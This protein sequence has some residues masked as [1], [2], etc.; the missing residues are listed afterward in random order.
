MLV[1]GRN[2][3]RNGTLLGKWIAII[4]IGCALSTV[5]ISDRYMWQSVVT[6]KYFWF[7]MVMCAVSLLIPFQLSK[8]KE[9][10]IADIL[11]GVLL[12]YICIN[13]F[14]LNGRPNMRLWLTLLMIPL[15]V[16][17]RTV[18]RNE[19]LMMWLIIV[20]MIVVFVEALVGLLQL[21]GFVRSHHILYK[22]TGTLFNPGPFSGFVAVGVP[23]ALRYALDKALPRWVRWLGISTLGASILVLSATMSRAAWM[24]TVAGCILI[25]ANS[26]Q[27]SRFK[28]QNFAY[29][30][31]SSTVI[32]IVMVIAAVLFVVVLTVGAYLLKKD[33]ADGRW[34]IWSA[35]IEAVKE[36]PLFGS[37]YGRFAAVYGNAQAAYFQVG[38]GSEGQK[39]VADSP[40][41]AFNEYVQM[42]VELGIAGL[43]LFLCT[44]GSVFMV[45]RFSVIHASLLSFI[46]FAA[47]SYPFSVLPLSILFVFLLAFSAPTS[48][49]LSISFPVWLRVAVTVVCW[50]IAA[51][52]SFQIL[53]KRMAY[54]DW[55]LAQFPYIEQSYYL[56]VKEYSTLYP[57]LQHEKQFLFEYGQ[58]LSK[59]GEYEK[60]NR[61]FDEYLR[62]GSDPM[63]YNCMGNN[64]KGMGDYGKA[65]KMYLRASQI[66]PNRHYP[67]YLL[68]KLYQETGQV[69]KAKEMANVLLEKSVKVWSTAIQEMQ[70]EARSQLRVDNSNLITNQN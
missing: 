36:R 50:G 40:E 31:L 22:I 32:R 35:S 63:V 26:I 16:A 10:Y 27:N 4:A 9:I 33:S 23:L 70:E 7:A 1:S 62:L 43:L 60:S 11:C 67:L 25:L 37:G 65:E 24:A 2:I 18:A 64:F 52:G 55:R 69:E 39:M 47:F 19:K 58:C 57:R 38:K 51:C 17:V 54:R 66:V 42:V 14:C 45:R 34:V 46:V 13:W 59:T 68:M 8:R 41:Y 5:F 30:C 29:Q 6:A 20:V 15:Y 53:P 61:I 3:F 49:Q 12:I 56:A 21:H 44:V 28:I 48:K